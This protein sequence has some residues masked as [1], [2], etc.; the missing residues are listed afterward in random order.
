M[1]R[2]A[3]AAVLECH[4]PASLAMVGLAGCAGA[5]ASPSPV[6]TD[7]VDLGGEP[8][9]GAEPLAV[10]VAPAEETL[11]DGDPGARFALRAKVGTVGAF[12]VRPGDP[13]TPAEAPQKTEPFAVIVVDERKPGRVRIIAEHYDVAYVLYVAHKDLAEVVRERARVEAGDA[14]GPPPSPPPA[15][16]GVELAGGTLIE[17][18]DSSSGRVRAR[19]TLPG[20]ALE[21][22]LAADHVGRTY[23]PDPFDLE[24]VATDLVVPSAL[25]LLDAPGGRVIA[26]FDPSAAGLHRVR[27]RGEAQRGHLPIEITFAEARVRG[28]V[29][30]QLVSPKSG[31]SL[32]G[33]GTGSGWGASHTQYLEVPL[34]AVFLREP[35]GPPFAKTLVADATI[36]LVDEPTYGLAKVA[37]LTPWGRIQGH[38]PC[39]A[40]EPVD[41]STS[42]FRCRERP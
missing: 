29:D 23:R 28:F 38:Y 11:L 10:E 34:G 24:L 12:A 36:V 40:V 1:R 19:V 42:R 6:P 26:R 18:V 41:G 17:R 5:G 27:A 14:H 16:V 35:E 15:G 8:E 31:L 2:A 20:L 13:L 22:W 39:A 7:V 30:A 4:L 21:G 9:A 25:D 3:W 37:F 33:T 32:S